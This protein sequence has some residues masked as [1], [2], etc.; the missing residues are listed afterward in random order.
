MLIP[1]LTVKSPSH[2]GGVNGLGSKVSRASSILGQ[3]SE[4]WLHTFR[5]H[6]GFVNKIDRYFV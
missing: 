4:P 6:K 3:A 2:L 1:V 5:A